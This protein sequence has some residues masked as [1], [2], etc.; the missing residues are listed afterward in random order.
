[1]SVGF[2]PFNIGNDYKSYITSNNNDSSIRKSWSGNKGVDQTG[3]DT[4]KSE[5]DISSKPLFDFSGATKSAATQG[6]GSG[7]ATVVKTGASKIIPEASMLDKFNA[8]DAKQ[9]NPES[10]RLVFDKYGNGSIDPDQYCWI[11]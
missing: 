5:S 9:L 6:I 8:M 11:A 1:M 7:V 3:S 10:S 2:N 4:Q